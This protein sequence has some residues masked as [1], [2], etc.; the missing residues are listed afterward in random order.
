M[1]VSGVEGA[2]INII[3]H[4]GSICS[5]PPFPT[6]IQDQGHGQDLEKRL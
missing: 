5:I 1:R 2:E 6:L 3:P 4:G